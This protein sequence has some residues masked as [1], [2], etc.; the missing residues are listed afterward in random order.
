[1]T[2]TEIFNDKLID[3]GFN[4]LNVQYWLSEILIMV[5]EEVELNEESKELLTSIKTDIDKT[6]TKYNKIIEL[7]TN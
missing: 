6:Q 7:I 5:K 4:I 3:A 1:M 2:K